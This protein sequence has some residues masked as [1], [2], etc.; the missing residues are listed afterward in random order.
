[1][2]QVPDINDEELSFVNNERFWVTVD[3]LQCK[4][5]I[6]GVYV[7]CQY[8]DDRHAEW[9][10]GIFWVLRQEVHA[11]RMAGYRVEVLGDFNG[12]VGCLT[13]QGIVGNHPDINLNGQRFLNFLFLL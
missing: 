13:G 3:S 2:I 9:N 4:T 12:H 5:A 1:M 6:C 7:G 8:G 10:D 11:L